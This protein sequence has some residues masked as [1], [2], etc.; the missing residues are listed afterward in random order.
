M[1]GLAT[2]I[3][4][5][6]QLVKATWRPIEIT[7]AVRI[8]KGAGA[9]G[10][11]QYIPEFAP[12]LA[13][14]FRLRPRTV[15]EI[16]THL[17][18]SFWAFCQVAPDDATLVS[19]DLPGGPGG[20]FEG[21]ATISKLRSYGKPGQTLEFL[22]GDSH[23]P[24]IR[25]QLQELIGGRDIDFLFIDGDHSKEGVSQDFETFAPS[26][27]AGGLIAFH[28]IVPGP[29]E[30]V[31]GVPVVWQQVKQVNSV[32]LVK[33]WRQGACGIGVLRKS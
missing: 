12:L 33:D 6:R 8:A 10:A 23:T 15:V 21:E 18:G 17:G 7:R 3:K 19:I 9:R 32:E 5:V 13:M 25:D 2:S 24:E 31:G 27:R 11:V 4:A 26:V 28:D 22:L 20:A 29:E 14:L 30:N 1:A 16:G